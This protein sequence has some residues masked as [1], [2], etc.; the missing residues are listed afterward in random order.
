[1]LHSKQ[2]IISRLILY[3]FL[4]VVCPLIIYFPF[5]SNQFKNFMFFLNLASSLGSLEYIN[6]YL[7]RHWKLIAR[8][9]FF[10]TTK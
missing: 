10:K 1:M 6:L 3:C 5:R 2:E 9:I 7:N 4:S 8:L